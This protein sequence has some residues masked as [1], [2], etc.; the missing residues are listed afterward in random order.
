MEPVD[1]MAGSPVTP[2]QT[3]PVSS[4]KGLIE[5]FY[6]PTAFFAKIKENPRVLVPWIIVGVVGLVSFY[7]LA[8]LLIDV[9]MQALRAR[10]DIPAGQIPSEDMMKISMYIG[11]LIMT[12]ILP[13]L[14]AG[15]AMFWGNFVLGGKTGFKQALSVVLYGEWVFTVLSIPV[16]L[17]ALAKGSMLVSIS[18]AILLANQGLE[19]PWYL[20][21]SKFG[22]RYIWE[23]IV[24]GIGFS[25]I[26]GFTRNKGYIIAVLSM[27]LVA[28]IHVLFALIFG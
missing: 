11:A 4:F 6:Q 24:L 12:I 3:A 17:M 2:N 20:L 25:A 23:F 5:V 16:V 10:E 13:L 9:Q 8:P 26:Y 7:F 22:L 15:L 28:L 27:G 18:P 19:S 1:H 14:Y 21:A